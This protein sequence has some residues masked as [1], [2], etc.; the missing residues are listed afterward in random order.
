METDEEE[1]A[2]KSATCSKNKK[3][4]FMRSTF[5]NVKPKRIYINGGFKTALV[6]TPH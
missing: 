4:S 3:R 1:Q 6:N 5:I 2:S